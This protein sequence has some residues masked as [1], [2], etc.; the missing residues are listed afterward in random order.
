M[1]LQ[2]KVVLVTGASRGIGQAI[3]LAFGREGAKVGLISRTAADQTADLIEG[4][5]SK[6]LPLPADVSDARQLKDAHSSLVS[7]FGPVDVLVN[8]AG[9]LLKTSLVDTSEEDWDR[10][11]DVNVKGVFL[12]SQLVT[13]SMMERRNGCIIN[14]SSIWGGVAV[15]NRSHYSASK[16]AVNMLTKAMALELA[17]YDIRVN[18]VAP[19]ITRTGLIKPLLDD[20]S[21]G[22]KFERHIPARRF[23]LPEE[24]AALAVYLASDRASYVT[25]QIIAVDG[26]L[27][28]R[29]ALPV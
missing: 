11:F 22:A 21:L 18:A 5:G 3:A 4:V 20:P 14:V 17:P 10:A 9:I 13:P 15:E 12:L 16:G 8:N 25:G 26:G 23:G 27:S 28:S 24:C 7:S 6:A 19:G 29:G 2:D 1:R